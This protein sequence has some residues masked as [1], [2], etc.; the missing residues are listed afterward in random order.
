[1][2]FLPKEFNNPPKIETNDFIVRP[3]TINDVVKDYDAVMSSRDHLWER[4]GGSWGW[5]PE[6]LSI[7]QD[8]IDL[9]WHQK[10]AQI[11]ST[12]NYAVMSPDQSRL[13]GC[14]YIDPPSIEGTD[15]EVWFWARQSE[16]LNGLESKIEDFVLGWLSEIWPFNVVSLNN[17]ICRID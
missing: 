7:E 13:L 6:D 10:E 15:A 1:M 5:P 8:L 14:I 2:R 16:L 12:F 4:F 11:Q 9:A 3:I 17:K